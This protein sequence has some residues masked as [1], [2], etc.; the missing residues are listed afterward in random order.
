MKVS[1][2]LNFKKDFYNIVISIKSDLE[3]RLQSSFKKRF[4][5]KEFKL[6]SGRYCKTRPMYY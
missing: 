5:H 6:K 4:V 2:K 1:L 3:L